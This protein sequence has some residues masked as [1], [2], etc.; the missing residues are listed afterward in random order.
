MEILICGREMGGKEGRNP[1]EYMYFSKL[2]LFSGGNAFNN[3]RYYSLLVRKRE[4][5]VNLERGPSFEP[6]SEKMIV[7][8]SANI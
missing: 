2:P 8:A 4:V 5:M 6:L 3:T 7:S 1:C